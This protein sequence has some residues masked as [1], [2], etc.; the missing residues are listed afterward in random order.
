[1]DANSSDVNRAGRARHLCTSSVGISPEAR[2]LGQYANYSHI[3][4]NDITLRKQT[5]NTQ[6]PM[7]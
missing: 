2:K 3:A 4:H 7:L 6:L 5:V 1:M